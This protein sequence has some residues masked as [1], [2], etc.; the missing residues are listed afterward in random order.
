MLGDVFGPLVRA[1]EVA[2]IGVARLGGDGW[3]DDCSF[4]AER[5][6]RA[7]VDEPSVPA[8]AAASMTLRVPPTLMS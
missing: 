6:H 4:E 2:D 3:P 7:R 1:E 8:R 5:P